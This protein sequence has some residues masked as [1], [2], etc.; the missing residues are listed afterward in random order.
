MAFIRFCDRT[1][2]NITDRTDFYLRA[3]CQ[4]FYTLFIAAML[5]VRPPEPLQNSGLELVAQL[6]CV[7]RERPDAGRAPHQ[8]ETQGTRA[9]AY[10]EQC[11][12]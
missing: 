3:R 7:V 12:R 8:T 11:V 4:H 5:N 10:I 2:L 9:G 6:L 1:D